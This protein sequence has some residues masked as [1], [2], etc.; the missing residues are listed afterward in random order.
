MGVCGENIADPTAREVA[1]TLLI[2]AVLVANDQLE[3]A[4][5]IKVA[6]SASSG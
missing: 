3:A 6:I 1:V 4:V 5:T 2:I